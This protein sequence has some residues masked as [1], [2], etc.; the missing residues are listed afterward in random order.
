MTTP[1]PLGR[2][3]G[4][5]DFEASSE[6]SFLGR[7]SATF[8]WSADGAFVVERADDESDLRTDP[9]WA[10]HSPMPVTAVLGF[11]DTFDECAML[12]ADARGVARIYRVAIT[13]EEWRVWRDA[14]GFFQRFVGTFRDEGRVIDGQWD[15]SEDGSAWRPDFQLVYRRRD[16]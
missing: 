9:G 7:G 2:L 4:T 8:S 16:G 1:S 6:G 14:P 5:W 13:D 12:Y 11:D 10:E 3:I 15:S